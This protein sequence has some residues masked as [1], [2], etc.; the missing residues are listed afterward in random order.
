MA[1][2]GA[3]SYKNI[4][5]DSLEDPR[6]ILVYKDSFIIIAEENQISAVDVSTLY[7]V[8]KPYIKYTL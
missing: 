8:S 4:T 2:H 5:S 7:D 1:K 6:S 3:L